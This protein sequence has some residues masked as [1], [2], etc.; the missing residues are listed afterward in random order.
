MSVDNGAVP[1][2]VHTAFQL[3]IGAA[4]LAVANAVL[5]LTF[6]VGTPVVLLGAAI[7]AGVLITA[8]LWMRRGSMR[9][10]LTLVSLALVFILY[11]LAGLLGLIMLMRQGPNGLGGLELLLIVIWP[12]KI[13]VLVAAV[14]QMYRPANLRYFS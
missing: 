10:R 13:V 11:S 12:I 4:A 6:K 1:A 9:A 14:W 2:P 8:G 7:E 3:I 5:Q